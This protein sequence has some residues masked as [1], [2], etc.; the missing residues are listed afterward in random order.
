VG[1]EIRD[2]NRSIS[3]GSNAADW[4]RYQKAKAYQSW[5]AIRH[6]IKEGS[7]PQIIATRKDASSL[8]RSMGEIEPWVFNEAE[9]QIMRPNKALQNH[10]LQKAPVGVGSI[11]GGTW[12]SALAPYEQANDALIQTLAP[13]DSFDRM[14]AD[15]AFYRLRMRQRNA[16]ATVAPVAAIVGE[17]QPKPITLM[18]FDEVKLPAR[19][20]IGAAVMS[21]E[22]VNFA[23]PGTDQAFQSELQKAVAKATDAEFVKI[24]SEGTGV[25]SHPSTGLTA[26]QFQA[27][28]QAALA[29]IVNQTLIGSKLY[30][31]LPVGVYNT[32]SLLRDGGPLIG[33][34]GM[35]GNIRVIGSSGATTDGV[36]LDASSI[37]ADSD[38][39]TTRLSDQD[40]VQMADNPTTG[41]PNRLIS[42]WQ[43]NLVEILAERFFGVTVMRPDGVAL[44]TGMAS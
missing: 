6:G 1:H 42:L 38:L 16:I 32:V 15:N 8:L 13:L 18:S 31:I 41:S 11:D 24:I 20:A 35:I 23:I 26:A 34:N 33:P 28:L 21:D 12:G 40:T 4:G 39:A 2:L 17:M 9:K 14:L 44:I 30:L 43:N 29:S 7:L 3:L 19:K 25:A 36:L 10:M 22:L 27:D 5:L 37:G